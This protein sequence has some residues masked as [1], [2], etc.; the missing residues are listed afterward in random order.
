MPTIRLRRGPSAEETALAETRLA[1]LRR[2]RTGWVPRLRA[3]PAARRRL[4]HGPA[5]ARRRS[6][7]FAGA[8][9]SSAATAA[10]RGAGADAGGFRP[11]RVLP[12]GGVSSAGGLSSAGWVAPPAV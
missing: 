10:G 5:A 1:A 3:I 6:A 4:V 12:A 8:A 2:P 9:G 11:A 7:G